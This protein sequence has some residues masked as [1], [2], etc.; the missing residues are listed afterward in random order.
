[1]IRTQVSLEKI[2]GHYY[3][4]NF[5]NIYLTG[6]MLEYLNQKGLQ[7]PTGI[8]RLVVDK[9]N[10]SLSKVTCQTSKMTHLIVKEMCVMDSTEWN[11]P[12]GLEFLEWNTTSQLPEIKDTKITTLIIGNAGST[13]RVGKKNIPQN[14]EHLEINS[15]N[16][17]FNKEPHTYIPDTIKSITFGYSMDLTFRSSYYTCIENWL[18][19]FSGYSV[20]VNVDPRKLYMQEDISY[21]P[22]YNLKGESWNY[23]PQYEEDIGQIYDSD[24][25]YS[26]C[27]D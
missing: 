10:G 11:V 9:F 18:P 14:L 22:F 27:E 3:Y 21:I 7:L 16:L 19:Q 5:K 17:G 13:S 23:Y 24:D 8:E 15:N 1:M 26:S 12:T 25:G 20:Y 4:N 2:L 6:E